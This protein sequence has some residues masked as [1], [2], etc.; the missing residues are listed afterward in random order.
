[1]NYII[2]ESTLERIK[3]VLTHVV[4]PS[5]LDNESSISCNMMDESDWEREAEELLLLV[6]YLKNEKTI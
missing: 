1:M 5:N 3:K 2:P 4:D 6:N